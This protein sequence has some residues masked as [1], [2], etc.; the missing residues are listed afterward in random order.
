MEVRRRALEA[1]APLSPPEVNEAISEAYQSHDSKLRA[2]AIYAMGQNCNPSWLPMLLKELADPSVEMRYEAA[3]A[4]GELGA[5][6]AV[7]YLAELINDEDVEVQLAAIQALGKIGGSVAKE[8][9]EQCQCHPSEVIQQTAGEA[10]HELEM[11][12]DPFS[13]RI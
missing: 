6:E 13:F 1:A 2:G 12:E 5:E 11:A 9:L 8:C 3:I 4:C 10:L 7:S